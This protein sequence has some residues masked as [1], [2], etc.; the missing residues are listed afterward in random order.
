MAESWAELLEWL[1]GI[2]SHV[3]PL[4]TGGALMAGYILATWKWPNF[5]RWHVI[6]KWLAVCF[7]VFALFQ[8]WQVEHRSKVA[9][10]AELHHSLEHS[11][12]LE[13][14]LQERKTLIEQLQA[15]IKKVNS[16]P[17]IEPK[18]FTQAACHSTSFRCSDVFRGR[19]CEPP[20]LWQW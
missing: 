15:A 3:V 14:Q 10:E 17:F 8:S 20:A 5:K 2:E 19:K 13:G 6:G 16:Q 11:A 4:L 12:R 1:G 9:R 7:F 18:N